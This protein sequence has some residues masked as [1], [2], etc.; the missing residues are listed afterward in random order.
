MRAEAQNLKNFAEYFK[1]D[2]AKKDGGCKWLW[3]QT[4]LLG[5]QKKKKTIFDLRQYKRQWFKNRRRIFLENNIFQSWLAAKNYY[6]AGC[7]C[8]SDSDF[9]AH[10][11]LNIG[12]GKF[13]FLFLKI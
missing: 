9:A 2:S 7:E 6:E 5:S 8:S 4:K 11:L 10:Y 3:R 13:C 1:I 12:E